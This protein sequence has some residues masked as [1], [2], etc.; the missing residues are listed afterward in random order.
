MLDPDLLHQPPRYVRIIGRFYCGGKQLQLG[1]LAVLVEDLHR[2]LP[3]CVSRTVQL[4]E[5]TKRAL[6]R[7]IGR[8]HRLD[9]RPVAV[10]LA[11]LNSL[12]L[13][14]KHPAR[15]MSGEN[16][17]FKRLGLHYNGFSI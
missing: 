15:I 6:P 10:F 16:L 9:Q 5:I 17:R 1:T 4:T 3:T 12:M 2:L 14:K 13:S 7:T 8:T 11:V